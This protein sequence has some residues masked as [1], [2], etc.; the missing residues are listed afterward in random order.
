MT[1]DHEL[2]KQQNEEVWD[3]SFEKMVHL[4]GA[5]RTYGRPTPDL[6]PTG[7]VPGVLC[8]VALAHLWARAVVAGD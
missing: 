2:I 7:Y 1:W 8:P 6:E 4:L 5:L 3:A